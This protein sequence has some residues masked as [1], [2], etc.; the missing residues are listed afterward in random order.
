LLENLIRRYAA[1]LESPGLE[2]VDNDIRMPDQVVCN[3][4]GGGILQI[5]RCASLA[6]AVLVDVSGPVRARLTA[7]ERRRAGAERVHT[8][9]RLDADDVGAQ[10]C[11][12]QAA[13][14]PCP[15]PR[16][17]DDPHAVERQALT[18]AGVGRRNDR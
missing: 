15:D 16:E 6:L 5:Q 1:A 3:L 2:I 14:G 17:G 13:H 8:Q 7:P 9:R 18:R 4:D 10:V 11:E 12:L